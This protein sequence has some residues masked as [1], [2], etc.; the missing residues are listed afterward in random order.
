MGFQR[1]VTFQTC[2]QISEKARPSHPHV[3]QSLKGMW[4]RGSGAE[5]GGTGDLSLVDSFPAAGA[6]IAFD[7]EGRSEQLIRAS[8]TCSL[9]EGAAAIT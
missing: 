6:I 2:P 9:V 7:P 8:S 5:G 4:P 3:D 1:G